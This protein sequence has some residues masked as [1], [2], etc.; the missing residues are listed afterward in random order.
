MERRCQDDQEHRKPTR[1]QD[2]D[3]T[4]CEKNYASQET[5][6]VVKFNWDTLKK[7]QLFFE[8]VSLFF[9]THKIYHLGNGWVIVRRLFLVSRSLLDPRTKSMQ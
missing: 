7:L 6:Q 4:Y 9:M 3:R 2:H 1:E 5:S 8:K